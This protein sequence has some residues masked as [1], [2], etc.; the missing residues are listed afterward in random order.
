MFSRAICKLCEIILIV[1]LNSRSYTCLS[2]IFLKKIENVDTYIWAGQSMRIGICQAKYSL[3]CTVCQ[4]IYIFGGTKSWGMESRTT[5]FVVQFARLCEKI[6]IVLLNS[7]TH[8][9][10]SW[11]FFDKIENVDTYIWA[12]QSMRTGV[13][14]AMYCIHQY[15]THTSL[16]AWLAWQTST[17]S[18]LKGSTNKLS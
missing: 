15:L 17:L 2:W 3:Q 6:L 5:C 12:S 8:I 7:R 10:L 9:H 11:I 1:L 18:L 14:R 13:C 16:W 4:H